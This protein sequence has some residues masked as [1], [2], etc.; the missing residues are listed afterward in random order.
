MFTV[1]QGGQ[2]P[3]HGLKIQNHLLRNSKIYVKYK[4]TNGNH[5]Q[6]MTSKTTLRPKYTAR[7]QAIAPPKQGLY[8]RT[9]G[10][11]SYRRDRAFAP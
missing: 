8:D 4:R 6:A 9:A 10:P 1:T 11:Q 3:R 7:G 2:R 5:C